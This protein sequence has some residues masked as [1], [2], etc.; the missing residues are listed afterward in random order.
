MRYLNASV[1]RRCLLLSSATVLWATA[2]GG[3]AYAHVKWFAD[4]NYATPPESFESVLT[5]TF[6]SM[7]ALSVV[8]LVVLVLVD[9]WAEGLAAVSRLS[10]WLESYSESSLLVMRVATFAT[11]LVAWQMG[12]LFAPELVVD[13]PWIER[14]QLAI[15]ILLFWVPTTTGAGLGLMAIW[16]YGAQ[17]FGFFH[18]LDYVNILGAAYFLAVRPLK[19]QRLRDTALPVLYA[20]LGFSLIWLACEKMV[21]PA[22]V[23]Y[24]LDQHPVLTLGLD[25]DFFR[26][27]AAFVELGLGYL[28]LIG[29]FGRSLSIIITLTF[30]LTTMVF[31]KVE[32]IGHTLIHAALLVFL[33]EGPGLA[34]RPPAYFHR[35]TPLRIAFAAVNFVLITFLALFLYI[36]AARKVAAETPPTPAPGTHEPEEHDHAHEHDESDHG[37]TTTS[38]PFYFGKSRTAKRGAALA[39]DAMMV[40]PAGSKPTVFSPSLSLSAAKEMRS[41][42]LPPT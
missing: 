6:W 9:K 13:N 7:L 18:M 28:L 41:V 42:P 26:V 25:R 16:L 19:N 8:T 15:I 17:R 14:L 22:W 11:L 39:I 3:S 4:F 35:T 29:L 36:A 33:F 30:F 10:R 21:Y 38:R 5:P 32:I 40:P 23:N 12:T 24:L 37:A 27:A 1:V 2:G 20:T 31:G 34:F